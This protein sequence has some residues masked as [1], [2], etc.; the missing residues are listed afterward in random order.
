M[1][2]WGP[3]GGHGEHP[4]LEPRSDAICQQHQVV[5]ADPA[6]QQ[7]RS[8]TLTNSKRDTSHFFL[9][10]LSTLR[11]EAL[12]HRH[13]ISPPSGWL[14]P[15]R[16]HRIVCCELLLREGRQLSTQREPPAPLLCVSLRWLAIRID[17]AAAGVGCRVGGASPCAR[18]RPGGGRATGWSK[19]SAAPRRAALRAGCRVGALDASH[20][21][22]RGVRG[23]AGGDVPERL[24]RDDVDVRRDSVASLCRAALGFSSRRKCFS[25]LGGVRRSRRR[26]GRAVFVDAGVREGRA[27]ESE[28][29]LRCLQVHRVVFAL[30]ASSIQNKFT[31]LTMC[32]RNDSSHRRVDSQSVNSRRQTAAVYTRVRVWAG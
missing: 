15:S 5:Q 14:A 9:R 29:M 16:C 6:P 13:G 7:D 4:Y 19:G 10:I 28:A 27:S 17:R 3:I 26:C 25:C 22:R 12:S 30:A 31:M 2:I 11:R 18:E 20:A 21:R 8:K 24:W 1:A 23:R 32:R